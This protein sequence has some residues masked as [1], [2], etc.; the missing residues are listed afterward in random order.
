MRKLGS[1]LIMG[2]AIC[3]MHYTGMAA[4]TFKHDHTHL[5]SE[6]IFDSSLLAYLIGI[7]ILGLAFVSIFIDRRFESQMM[8]SE[9]RF[10]SVVGSAHDAFILADN[11]GIIISWNKGAHLILGYEEQ[12]LIGEKLHIIFPDRYLEDHQ[13]RLELLLTTGEANVFGR[14]HELQGLRKDQSELTC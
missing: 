9:K 1:S 7:G 12:E 11:K 8:M 2:I 4:A 10:H 14:T 5:G 13:E 6:L 3:G